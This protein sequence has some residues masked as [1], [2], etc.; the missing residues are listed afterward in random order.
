MSFGLGNFLYDIEVKD[1][2][3]KFNFRDPEDA[4]NTAECTVDE[5]DFG[6]FNADSRQVAE[7]A[8]AQVSKTLNDKRDARVKKQ[9]AEAH[10]ADVDEKARAREAEADFTNNA[11]DVAVEP[12]QVDSDGTR[13]Y[14]TG[15][16][17]GTTGANASDE[18]SK[19]GK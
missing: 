2:K 3:A 17:D 16:P 5:K 13:V 4:D 7:I 6:G 19:K 10:A 12:A 11:R 9:T 1:G 15:A 18:T 14:N 8:Y